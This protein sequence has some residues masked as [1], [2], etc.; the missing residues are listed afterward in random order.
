MAEPT[1]EE[2]ALLAQGV[3]PASLSDGQTGGGNKAPAD[4]GVESPAKVAE[5]AKAKEDADKLAAAKEAEDKA[6]AE[7]GAKKKAGTDQV[8]KTEWAKSDDPVYNSV[9]EMLTDAGVSPM[10]GSSIFDKAVASGNMEDIDWDTLQKKVKPG[11]FT[12]IKA[13]VEKYYNDAYAPIQ[14]TVKKGYEIVGGEE[15]WVKVRDWAQKAEK[16]G[17]LP[18]LDDI[19]K[20]I[21]QNGWIAEQGLQKLKELYEK[22]PKNKGLG[23]NKITEGN[24]NTVV[25]A[26]DALTAA[27]YR[28]ELDKLRNGFREPDPKKLAAL[29]ARRKAGMQAGI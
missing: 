18:Q 2:K 9:I 20:A 10:E 23:V 5:A 6:K 1:A 14:A 27:D 21:A 24:V 7:E 3:T 28:A 26:G 8:G 4:D 13:G 29:Q 25:A 17:A 11:Q 22:D 12:L 15:N 19:R 16:A